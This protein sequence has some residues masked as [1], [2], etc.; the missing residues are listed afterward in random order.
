MM[1]NKLVPVFASLILFP[2][3]AVAK[4]DVKEVTCYK[5]VYKEVYVPGNKNYP[6]KVES[7]LVK[8]EVPCGRNQ[9]RHN[10]RGAVQRHCHWHSHHDGRYHSHCHKHGSG[11]RHHGR[12]KPHDVP[13]LQRESTT[14]IFDF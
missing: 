4:P 13:W 6:G 9:R 11:W 14:I 3:S 1:I 2:T 5:E 10:N 8:K 12:S 7:R